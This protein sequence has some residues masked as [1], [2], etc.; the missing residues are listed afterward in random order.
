VGPEG[1]RAHLFAR[2]DRPRRIDVRIM[3]D[4]GLLYYGDMGVGETIRFAGGQTL[5]LHG[6][7]LW[8]GLRG[9]RD[10]SVWPAHLGFA[11][12][13]AGSL[14]L[15]VLPPAG[16]KTS[17]ADGRRGASHTAAPMVVLL[18][19]AGLAGCARPSHDQARQR[20]MHYND[21]VSEAYRRG[22]A[23]LVDSVAGPNEGKKLTGLIG[24]RLDLGLT[25]DSQLLAI[26][27]VDVIRTRD[28]MRVRTREEWRYCDRKIGTGDQVGEASRDHYE[29]LYVFRNINKAW[30]VDEIQFITPPKVGRKTMTWETTRHK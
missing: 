10:Y 22:D 15:F 5:T 6:L 24:V 11:L 26:E 12:I 9:S 30:L 19:L 28:E 20:V 4:N 7:P 14:L 25:L 1:L 27:V 17:S 13:L 18:L 16:T 8:V 2:A 23:R 21:V 29:M 3:R